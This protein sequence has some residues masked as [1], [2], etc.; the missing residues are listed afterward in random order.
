MGAHFL[1]CLPTCLSFLFVVLCATRCA[2]SWRC[3]FGFSVPVVS[4]FTCK[5]EN[6]ESRKSCGRL[7]QFSSKQRRIASTFIPSKLVWIAKYAVARRPAIRRLDRVTRPMTLAMIFAAAYS[8]IINITLTFIAAA[9]AARSAIRHSN[10]SYT[11]QYTFI[12]EYIYEQKRWEI[13][14]LT[15][16]NLSLFIV[17]IRI[18]YVSALLVYK[19]K[20]NN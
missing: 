2:D 20:I 11:Q 9:V 4:L 19:Q 17:P 15:N 8:S 5:K 1:C 7:F 6:E 18:Y 14:Q 13:C 16:D 10:Y 12:F 3:D